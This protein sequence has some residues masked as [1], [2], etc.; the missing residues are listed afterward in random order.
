LLVQVHAVGL[1][2]VDAKGVIGDKLGHECWTTVRKWAHNSLVKNTRV[3]FDFAGVV[4]AQA[5][6]HTNNIDDYPVGT[7]VFGTMPPLQGSCGEYIQV[8]LDQVARVPSHLSM[9]EAA[10]LSLV[11]LTAWQSLSPCIVRDESNVLILGGSGGTG[12]VSIQVAKA[13][14]AKEITT[15]CSTRNMD[16]C[17]ECGATTVIDYTSSSGSGGD[18][19]ILHELQPYGPFDVILDCVT[20]ADPSDAQHDYPSK[21]RSTTA[22]IVASQHLYLRLGA[23]L[24]SDWMRAGLARK[25]NFCSYFLPHDSSWLWKD[26]R[27]RLFW[28]RFPQSSHE[29]EELVKLTPEVKPR[30]QRVYPELTAATVQQA[31]DDILSRR[32]QGKVVVRVVP[33]TEEEQAKRREQQEVE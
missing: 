13:L 33:T 15:V 4:V 19:N 30:I 26:P 22:G 6:P 18:D 31:F 7:R 17:K 5:H 28:I 21:I 32:V 24:S 23:T 9:E 27:E 29:L 16:F 1:N 3:G 20:S 11:G 25:N 10:A 12:H 14:G 8:P 2:P